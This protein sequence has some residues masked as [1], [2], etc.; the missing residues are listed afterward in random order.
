MFDEVDEGTAI[1]KLAPHWRDA[2]DQGFWLTLDVDGAD[3]PS[4]CYPRLAGET[5]GMFH[6][7]V[8]PDA[9]VPGH[10]AEAQVPVR[11]GR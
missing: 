10:P 1:F 8:Q 4:D 9:R 6:G 7:E 11:T 3:L 5:T 2:P